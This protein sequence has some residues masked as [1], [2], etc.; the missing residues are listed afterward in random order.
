MGG[1]SRAANAPRKEK[2]MLAKAVMPIRFAAPVESVPRPSASFSKRSSDGLKIFIW[3][4]DH[5]FDV[6]ESVSS[7]KLIHHVDH[8]AELIREVRCLSKEAKEKAVQ[9]NRRTDDAQLSRLKVEDETRSLRVK[10]LESKL[11]KAEARVL[12]EREAGKA[13]AEAARVEA[14]KA[15]HTSKEFYNIKMDFASLSYLQGGIDLK[16]KV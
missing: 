10:Q 12:G 15:F 16:E 5:G 14:V 11:A 2:S 4:S 6:S 8:F 3:M 7:M 9:A 1:S 13:R